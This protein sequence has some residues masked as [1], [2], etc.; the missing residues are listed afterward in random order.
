MGKERSALA[1]KALENEEREIAA[2]TKRQQFTFAWFYAIYIKLL[3]VHLNR[4]AGTGPR[5]PA[6]MEAKFS[7]SKG[8]RGR[9]VGLSVRLGRR[10]GILTAQQQQ[11]GGEKP[12]YGITSFSCSGDAVQTLSL[13]QEYFLTSLYPT[14]H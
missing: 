7:Q 12:Q 9:S 2:L 11:F 5:L 14:K 13:Y 3:R 10:C 4:E 1:L 8:R 6:T